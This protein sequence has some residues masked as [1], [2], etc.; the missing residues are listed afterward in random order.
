MTRRV[1]LAAVLLFAACARRSAFLERSVTVN[2]HAYRY[3]IWLPARYTKLHHWPVILY[4]HG[5]GERGDDNERQLSTGLAPALERYGQRYKAVVV[6]PQCAEGHEWYG[7]ME[8][9]A[10]SALEQTIREFHGDRRRVVVTGI[11]MGGV[12]AWYMARHRRRWAAVVPISGA[13]VRQPSDPFPSDLPPDIARIAYAR[14]PYDTLAEEIGT[15]PVWALHGAGDEVIPVTES[16]NMVAA[17]KRR[18]GNVRHTEYV[19]VGHD[20]W[21]RA[22]ADPNLAHWMLEQKMK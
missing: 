5:S 17:L 4:L 1:L 18:G 8:Q 19:G 9:M 7:E 15:T 14:D 6:L 12:G 11:S 13:V 16:R 2:N 20:A 10:Q 22:Y 21:D 3:R